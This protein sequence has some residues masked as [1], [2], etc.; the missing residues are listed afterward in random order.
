MPGNETGPTD[1]SG[2]DDIA[3]RANHRAWQA[4]G[5]HVMSLLEAVGR[6]RHRVERIDAE[7]GPGV[8]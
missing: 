7:A 1:A 6:S 2:E 4:K 5:G 8:A 3:A